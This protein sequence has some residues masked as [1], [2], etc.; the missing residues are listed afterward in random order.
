MYTSR[1][2][3]IRTRTSKSAQIK[4]KLLSNYL[5]CDTQN[6]YYSVTKTNTIRTPFIHTRNPKFACLHAALK[7]KSRPICLHSPCQSHYA[8][9]A[10]GAIGSL[11]VMV[12]SLTILSYTLI[13]VNP[14]KDFSQ[15]ASYPHQQST[16]T[17]NY[18]Q[19]TY[20]IMIVISSSTNIH[21]AVHIDVSN[22]STKLI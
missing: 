3:F 1:T 15:H 5:H 7:S 10:S 22:N 18:S 6:V 17:C 21:L 2:P 11:V 19:L 20:V 4:K 8:E 9:F 14:T 16:K 12:S 13:K